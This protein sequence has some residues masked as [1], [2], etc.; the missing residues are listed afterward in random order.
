MGKGGIKVVT[1]LT[2]P[3]PLVCQQTTRRHLFSS[4]SP[5]TFWAWTTRPSASPA[6]GFSPTLPLRCVYIQF[7]WALV[8]MK[9]ISPLL[10]PS[11]L[12]ILFPSP[13]PPSLFPSPLSPSLFPFPLPPSLFPPSL[14]YKVPDSHSPTVQQRTD[15]GLHN[16]RHEDRQNWDRL[17]QLSSAWPSSGL[18]S[19]R[20]FHGKDTSTEIESLSLYGW[21]PAWCA[22]GASTTEGFVKEHFS[23]VLWCVFVCCCV[24]CL[25]VV[26][27]VYVLCCLLVSVVSSQHLCW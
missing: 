8:I 6:L 25:H 23:V 11:P 12:F 9:F 15:E 1:L 13:L 3:S 20:G 2:C 17:I 19:R 27:F 4:L 18:A 24:V 22:K 21:R 14:L 16:R 10:P 5:K 7:V 26:L